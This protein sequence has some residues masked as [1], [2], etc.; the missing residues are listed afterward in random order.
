MANHLMDLILVSLNP[1]SDNQQRAD[2][3][4]RALNFQEVRRYI[5][6]NF[7]DPT[8]NVDACASALKCSR[9]YLQKVIASES[10]SFTDLL[11]VRRIEVACQ[12]IS[13][14]GQDRRRL[15]D[16]AF[17]CGFSDLSTFYRAFKAVQG[18]AP[19]DYRA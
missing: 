9:S 19:G 10:T 15:V 14:T 6:L 17:E 11:R 7:A 3:G 5:T 2:K 16:V 18:V 1:S 4:V 12:M 8:C 13:A